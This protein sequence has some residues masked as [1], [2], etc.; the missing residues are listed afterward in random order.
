M[1][2]ENSRSSLQHSTKFCMA[3][4]CSSCYLIFTLR[5]WDWITFCSQ[6]NPKVL[7]LTINLPNSLGSECLD[8][9]LFLFET[10]KHLS[11]LLAASSQVATRKGNFCRCTSSRELSIMRGPPGKCL[12]FFFTVSQGLTYLP[13]SLVVSSSFYL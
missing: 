7:P 11:L 13:M 1:D 3:L 2:Q 8:I 12:S 4:F 9:W 5:Y 10:T 6:H